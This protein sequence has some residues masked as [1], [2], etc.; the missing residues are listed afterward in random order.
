MSD[1]RELYQQVI[2]DHY[3]SPH[4]RHD[5][6]HASHAAEGYNPL[7]GDRVKLALRVEDGIVTEVGFDGEGCAIATASAS[8]MTDLIKGKTL[9]QAEALIQRFHGM[10][11]S[12]DEPAQRDTEGLG[13]TTI[14]AGVREFPARV[15]CATL[16]WRT[17]EAALQGAEH[18][19]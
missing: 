12:E 19:E 15:K 8:L 14:L 11:T 1:I 10:V 2:F 4:N 17:L 18:E 3:R 13:K 7:C 16:A 6:D 9:E 5:V